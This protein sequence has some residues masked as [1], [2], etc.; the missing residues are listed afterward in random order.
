VAV[1]SAA[2]VQ[3]QEVG[4]AI[5]TV[6][7]AVVV[8]DLDGQ[9]VDLGEWVGN[10]PVLLEFWATWCPICEALQPRL[11]AAHARYGDQVRFAA[12]AVG[13][14]QSPRSIRRHLEDHPL[15]YP[16]LWDGRGR[17]TRTYRAPT[18][19]Y[20]VI[21]DAEGRVAYTGVGEDQDLD[22]ALERV[23]ER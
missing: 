18:T 3:A 4:L 22:A 17:A 21:L 5:G 23:V 16:M 20:I 2:A 6:P 15:P 14:N 7:E 8:E 19:S 12:V 10:G 11:D 13:V 1:A 9:P